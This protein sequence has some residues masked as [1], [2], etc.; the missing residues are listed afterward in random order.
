MRIWFTT[1]PTVVA[2]IRTAIALP[3]LGMPAYPYSKFR[4]SATIRYMENHSN[5]P[6]KKYSIATFYSSIHSALPSLSERLLKLSRAKQ[7]KPF[8][9]TPEYQIQKS[10]TDKKLQEIPISL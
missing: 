6:K 1:Y 5:T 10:L 3:K 4:L 8:C 9:C 7:G 2:P